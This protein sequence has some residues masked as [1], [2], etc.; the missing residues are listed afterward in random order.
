[1]RYSIFS[2]GENAT[3]T[4]QKN[5]MPIPVRQHWQGGYSRIAT[6]KYIHIV[7]YIP[8]EREENYDRI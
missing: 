7:A 5:K 3:I 2:G 4:C 8:A 6:Q 1:M